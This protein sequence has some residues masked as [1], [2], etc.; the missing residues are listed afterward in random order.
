MKKNV[1]FT[2]I[3]LMIT[4]AIFAIL[5]GIGIPSYQ[6]TVQQ[7]R[8]DDAETLITRTLS[9]S[10]NTAIA[11]NRTL[12]MRAAGN[13]LTLTTADADIVN[14]TVIASDNN[15]TLSFVGSGTAII[16]FRENGTIATG[17]TIRYCTGDAGIEIAVGLTGIA[18]TTYVNC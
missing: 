16:A 10:K 13:V 9:Y 6:N 7:N 14:N 15:A 1:G 2:L 3:E 4:V 8:I 12:F 18:A 11:H 17:N 5:L